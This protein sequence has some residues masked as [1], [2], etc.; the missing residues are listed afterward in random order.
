MTSTGSQSNM[1]NNTNNNVNLAGCNRCRQIGQW[2]SPVT[3]V[4]SGY[5]NAQKCTGMNQYTADPRCDQCRNANK[6]CRPFRVRQSSTPASGAPP[7]L[8]A[9]APGTSTN[10]N[11]LRT[12]IREMARAN[13]ARR[14][15]NERLQNDN[16]RLNARL[17][18]MN[19]PL[20]RSN[21][22]GS[23]SQP[24]MNGQR[25]LPQFAPPRAGNTMNTAATRNSTFAAPRSNS[26]TSQAA[27]NYY[28]ASIFSQYSATYTTMQMQET[29]N[30]ISQ[31]TTTHV[32][33]QQMQQMHM[34]MQQLQQAA[35]QPQMLQPA[36]PAQQPQMPNP[37]QNVAPMASDSSQSELDTES[38]GPQGGAQNPDGNS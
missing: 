21:N 25:S 35:Q 20:R 9:A 2:V 34:Q 37:Q 18:A 30:T 8:P 17:S 31:Y 23:R 19:D 28:A 15:A 4:V 22:A 10:R 7:R 32:Q 3:V 36:Q 6:E 33:M 1:P 12:R 29:G 27:S 14:N 38:T 5:A 24:G 13:A 26:A 16:D 11:T